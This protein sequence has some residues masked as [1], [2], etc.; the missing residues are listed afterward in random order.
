MTDLLLLQ[1][2]SQHLKNIKTSFENNPFQKASLNDILYFASKCLKRI[3]ERN[4][5]KSGP[6]NMV[7]VWSIYRTG[8]NN[9]YVFILHISNR[10][11]D[12][13]HMIYGPLT[14]YQ[15]VGA[16]SSMALFLILNK[17][18]SHKT[19]KDATFINFCLESFQNFFFVISVIS[20]LCRHFEGWVL[21]KNQ[22]K[23]KLAMKIR[24]VFILP[25]L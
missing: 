14:I 16:I 12:K 13:C 24:V 3:F 4:H 22:L 1:K 18:F 21:K 15:A 7:L 25:Y 20:K 11:L 23:K 2:H 9:F 6:S 5:K 19:S 8:S 10:P 17:F